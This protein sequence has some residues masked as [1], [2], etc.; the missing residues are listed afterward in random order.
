MDT[1]TFSNDNRESPPPYDQ[2]NFNCAQISS[3]DEDDDEMPLGG[4]A[5]SGHVSRSIHVSPTNIDDIESSKPIDKEVIFDFNKQTVKTHLLT[6]SDDENDLYDHHTHQK[7]P[8]SNTNEFDSIANS[9]FGFLIQTWLRDL[10]KPHSS[11]PWSKS[12]Q[13]YILDKIQRDMDRFV[14]F[15]DYQNAIDVSKKML[16]NN[17]LDY[18]YHA[19]YIGETLNVCGQCYWKSQDY[20]HAI[21]Y[22]SEA[23]EYNRKDD[24]A[25]FFRARAFEDEK[26]YVIRKN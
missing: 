21:E 6:I 5:D 26:L 17:Q 20:F 12:P 22:T 13:P 25:L 23:L 11:R 19:E 8:S 4:E 2:H 1:D 24:N 15:N 16:Q 18:H 3:N 7:Y 10:V 14:R 9:N